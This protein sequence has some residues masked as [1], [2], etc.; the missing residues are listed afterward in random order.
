MSL[1][2][3]VL[4]SPPNSHVYYR[5]DWSEP[6]RMVIEAAVVKK[7]AAKAPPQ[8]ALGKEWVCLRIAV[9]ADAVFVA[10]RLG[11]RAVINAHSAEQLARRISG[12]E[13]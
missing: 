10:H 9:G 2:P 5:G 6:E 12:G 13:R 4:P 11:E 7:T 3:S 1:I 8:H